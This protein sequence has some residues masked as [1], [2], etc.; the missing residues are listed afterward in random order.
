M[1]FIAKFAKE[2]AK[3]AKKIKK[4]Q[5]FFLFPWRAWSSLA[6]LAI[7]SKSPHTHPHGIY[8]NSY[9]PPRRNVRSVIEYRS[10]LTAGTLCCHFQRASPLSEYTERGCGSIAKMS[11]L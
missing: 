9:T 2:D 4:N 5:S 6:N 3:L 8:W 1:V 11:A 7:K 10:A